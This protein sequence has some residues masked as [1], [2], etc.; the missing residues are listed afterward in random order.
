MRHTLLLGARLVLGGYLAVHGAQKLFGA[1]GGHGLEKT[2]AGFEKIGLT[3][4][5]EMATLAGV[6]EFGGGLLTATGI[7][8]PLGPVAIMG[9]M[10]VASAT[11]RENGPLAANRGFELPLTNLAAAA[12]LATTDAGRIRLGPALPKSLVL[13]AVAGGGAAAAIA[14]AKLLSPP[15]PA[16]DA[17]GEP[18]AERAAHD[19]AAPGRSEPVQS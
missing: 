12:A 13:I 11:H 5:R 9:A 2:A 15:Q 16:S 3:P 1:F 4:G 18:A 17:D 10:A 19:A 6:S 14:L 7:A 8:H